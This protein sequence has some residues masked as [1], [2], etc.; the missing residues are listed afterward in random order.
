MTEYPAPIALAGISVHPEF[1]NGFTARFSY[2]RSMK[3]SFTQTSLTEMAIS[4]TRF[5]LTLKNQLL[6]R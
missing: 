3:S 6:S 4:R 2:F 1:A 5:N